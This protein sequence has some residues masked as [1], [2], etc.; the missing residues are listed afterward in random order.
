MP[1][2]LFLVMIGATAGLIATRVMQV[3]A[4]LV[5][6]VMI[7]IAGALLGWLVLRMLLAVSGWVVVSLAAVGGAMA[8]LWLWKTY[9]G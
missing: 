8:L 4:D 7:G 2:I 1:M 6:T 9:R 3:R 5:T